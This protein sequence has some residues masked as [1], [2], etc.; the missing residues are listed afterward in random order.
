MSR[1]FAA[2][3]RSHEPHHLREAIILAGD[4]LSDPV[5]IRAI[6]QK[7]LIIIQKATSNKTVDLIREIVEDLEEEVNRRQ[8]LKFIVIEILAEESKSR[9][10]EF[11]P[12]TD[13]SNE[14][15][16]L[17]DKEAALMSQRT[18][19]F[20][21]TFDVKG[22][23]GLMAIAEKE[24]ILTTLKKCE[25]NRTLTAKVLGTSIRTLRNKLNL[26][27]GLPSNYAYRKSLLH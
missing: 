7:A 4:A 13:F 19:Y 10:I 12:R 16:Y 5:F 14:A 27:L 20:F 17:S 25:F 3:S 15:R 8:A 1:A 21:D 22:K 26:Y 2:L 9:V 18:T 11:I 23:R 6:H 24:L